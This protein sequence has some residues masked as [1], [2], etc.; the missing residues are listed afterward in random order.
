MKFIT[1]RKFKFKV[2]GIPIYSALLDHR[3]KYENFF[4]TF[5]KVRKFTNSAE[6]KRFKI[7]NY[8]FFEQ[9][10]TDD[11]IYSKSEFHK[12][13]TNKLSVMKKYLNTQIDSKYTKI[14]IL[15]SNL[16]EAYIFLKY[17]INNLTENEDK[18]L[19]ACTK[20]S[21]VSIANM[22]LP[23]VETKL[24]SNTLPEIE[25]NTFKIG[26]QQYYIAFPMKFY[27]NTESA[28][29][30]NNAVYLDEIYKY[31]NI[32]AKR[33]IENTLHISKAATQK[34]D[35]YL[36]KNNIQKFI[37]IVKNA[38]TCTTIPDK[39]WNELEKSLNIKVIYNNETMPLD[40]TYYLAAKSEAIISLRCG[41]SEILSESGKPHI[42]LYTDFINRF[43]FKPITK[44][45][46]ING[47]SIKTVTPAANKIIE[48]EYSDNSKTKII[49]SITETLLHKKEKT[50]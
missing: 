29:N 18:I 27:I 25:Y 14:F 1:D 42:I 5:F 3:I 13:Y 12:K 16:G 11:F 33:S 6:T 45:K 26:A 2:L 21:H 49:K 46:I 34:I 23:N 38:K 4:N 9:T 35:N 47:Y 19:I 36:V 39:F 41:L 37:F 7:F 43:R 17:I 28:I 44:D 22:L 40:E 50:K 30:N 32:S 31:F 10:E 24:L 20:K 15:K 48:I 8:T